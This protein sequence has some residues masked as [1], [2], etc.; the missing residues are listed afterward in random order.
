MISVG[1]QGFNSLNFPLTQ[2]TIFHF[3]FRR[4]GE[5][6]GRGSIWQR[7]RQANLRRVHNVNQ[8]NCGLGDMCILVTGKPDLILYPHIYTAVGW[9]AHHSQ[10]ISLDFPEPHLTHLTPF[11]VATNLPLFFQFSKNDK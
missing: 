8:C 1:N 3:L 9:E 2:T 4:I 11:W 5:H 7:E 6:A 10:H